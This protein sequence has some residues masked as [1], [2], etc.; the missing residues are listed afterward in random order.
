MRCSLSYIIAKPFFHPICD[1]HGEC[2]MVLVTSRQFHSGS[3][4]DVHVRTTID[5]FYSYVEA[6]AIRVGQ[7]VLEF[8]SSEKMYFN[9]KEHSAQEPLEFSNGKHNCKYSLVEKEGQKSVFRLDLD[10][11]WIFIKF[12]DK[13]MAVDIRG[14][15]YKALADSVG[16]M[17]NYT[18]GSMWSRKGERFT[19]SFE[20]YGFEWQVNPRLGDPQ[21]FVN[22]DRAPQLPRDQCR[23]PSVARPSRRH[24]RADTKLYQA[25]KSACEQVA[26]KHDV[27]LCINDI[28][29]TGQLGLAE[30]W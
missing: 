23:L 5:A 11:S 30:V 7:N 19:S 25:A 6:A 9:G 16:L 18:D 1:S 3:G 12:W 29:A 2:D 27:E 14:H 26:T 20:A 22:H 8:A 24:L 13:F 17:G 10:T 15:G 21:L 28:M 4:L